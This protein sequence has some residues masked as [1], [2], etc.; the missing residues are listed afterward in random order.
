MRSAHG[1]KGKRNT[2]TVLWK[3]FLPPPKIHFCRNPAGKRPEGGGKRLVFTELRLQ[4]GYNRV[5]TGAANISATVSP[6]PERSC[7]A[8]KGG[9]E[10]PSANR[11]KQRDA[12]PEAKARLCAQRSF[13]CKLAN[14]RKR[15][16]AKPEAKARYVCYARSAATW[17]TTGN[18][19]T[20]SQR[21]KRTQCATLV[22]LPDSLCVRAYKLMQRKEEYDEKHKQTQIPI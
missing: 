20:Q 9:E 6:S 22:R 2:T 8:W 15:Q 4:P 3:A 17:Q 13:G 18:G 7:P 10:G 11:W 12:K 16:D 21:L 19:G 14:C 1:R 5:T